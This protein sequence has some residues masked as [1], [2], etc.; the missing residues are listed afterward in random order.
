M[1]GLLQD[2]IREVI[3][4]FPVLGAVP[5]LGALF[6]SSE[7]QKNETEL[8]IIV[9]P[10]LVKPLDMDKQ[11]LPTDEFMEPN[12]F[13]FYLMGI[14]ESG[15]SKEKGGKA[16]PMKGTNASSGLEGDFGPMMPN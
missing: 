10:H 9:T 11:T 8:I 14:A 6:R 1:A 16:A 15:F 4:K 13:D 5:V 3:K 12:D 7:F 2:N